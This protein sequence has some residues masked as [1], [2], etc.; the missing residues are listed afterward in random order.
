MPRL[1]LVL[2]YEKE[3]K[4]KVRIVEEYKVDESKK[5]QEELQEEAD[6]EVEENAWRKSPQKLK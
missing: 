6:K 5:L 1:L 4:S 3:I 2:D